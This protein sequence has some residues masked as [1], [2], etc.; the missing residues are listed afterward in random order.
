MH[1]VKNQKSDLPLDIRTKSNEHKTLIL[2]P[3][4]HINILYSF[5]LV[6]VPT[7]LKTQIDKIL[8]IKNNPNCQN[9][10]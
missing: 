2:R 5:Y 10:T 6:C 3:E 1:K 7:R 9:F 8:D 4:S